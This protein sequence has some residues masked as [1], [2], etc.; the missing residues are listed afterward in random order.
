MPK[1]PSRSNISRFLPPATAQPRLPGFESIPPGRQVTIVPRGFLKTVPSEQA[2]YCFQA[3][4]LH[5]SSRRRHVRS[6]KSYVFPDAHWGASPCRAGARQATAAQRRV[7]AWCWVGV[8]LAKRLKG[9]Q[10]SALGRSARGDRH[11]RLDTSAS[12]CSPGTN[13]PPQRSHSAAC[14]IRYIRVDAVSART[15]HRYLLHW[16][17]SLHARA[18][19]LAEQDGVSLSVDRAAVAQK[20]NAIE[21]RGISGPCRKCGGL[22]SARQRSGPIG[23]RV[24]NSGTPGWWRDER[25]ADSLYTNPDSNHGTV[26]DLLRTP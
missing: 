25:S 22:L 9:P 20:I 6:S 26:S 12:D 2:P 24:A 23:S 8:R 4:R 3:D 13:R 15:R 19:R 10:T 14:H 5:R 16:P 18:M 21:S 17:E 7:G 11:D 1:R